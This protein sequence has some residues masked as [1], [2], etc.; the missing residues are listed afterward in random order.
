MQKLKPDL[1]VVPNETKETPRSPSNASALIDQAEAQRAQQERQER[2][3]SLIQ[4][5]RAACNQDV[6]DPGSDEMLIMIGAWGEVL[7]EI[8][9]SYLDR[10]YLVA[11]KRH[12]SS[13]PLAV[14][15][16]SQVWEEK[17]EEWAREA[18]APVE[19][20]QKGERCRNPDCLDGFEIVM[21]PTTKTSKGARPCP[22]CNG[23][24]A[25]KW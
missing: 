14:S 2:I 7:H 8:P 1:K 17:G 10:C 13:F 5:A 9:L 16:I 3:F 12:K 18:Q 23:A 24:Q 22:K 20:R 6:L 11:I 19:P 21:D 4:R 25:A 15:E